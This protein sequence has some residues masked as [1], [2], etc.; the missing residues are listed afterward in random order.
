MKK[1][2]ML[3][4]VGL[5]CLSP[6][7]GQID[8]LNPICDLLEVYGVSNNTNR[9]LGDAYN[10][11]AAKAKYPAAIGFYEWLGYSQSEV[12]DMDE[13]STAAN[14]CWWATATVMSNMPWP[15]VL[16]GGSY[17]G[18][19]TGKGVVILPQGRFDT[20]MPLLIHNSG[21]ILCEGK[22]PFFER[23]D[24]YQTTATVLHP[25]QPNWV[26][27]PAAPSANFTAHFTN[28]I[29]NR[30][31]VV[32]SINFG[33]NFGGG[34][35][36]GLKIENL[37]IS[38]NRN[39]VG[40][41]NDP[42]WVGTGIAIYDMGETSEITNNYIEEMN[43]YG[44]ECVF[45][46][47]N[48]LYNNST[49]RCGL[50]GVMITG[51]GS[52]HSNSRIYGASGDDNGMALIGIQDG[53]GFTAGGTI[54]LY[55]IKH[56]ALG[57]TNY[58]NLTSQGIPGKGQLLF[59]S[60]SASHI[61]NLNI[62]GG[63]TKNLGCAIDALIRIQGAPSGIRNTVN[64]QGLYIYG[65]NAVANLLQVGG[66]RY[67]YP[68]SA[69]FMAH[70]FTFTSDPGA[71]TG[72]VVNQ[73]GFVMNASSSACTT[74]LAWLPWNGFTVNGSWNYT[75]C[76]PSWSPVTG[77]GGVVPPPP[78]PTPAVPTTVNITATPSAILVSGTSQASATILDQYNVPISGSITWSIV[79][80]PGTVNGS[81]FV[82][83]T[84]TAG[85]IIV[86]GT[87]VGYPLVTNTANIVVTAAPSS[88]LLYS[89]VFLGQN[90]LA[91]VPSGGSLAPTV[92]IQ[93]LNGTTG[94][95]TWRRGEI[96]GA[97]FSTTVSGV[98]PPNINC[99][100][101]LA[102]PITGV[103][104]IILKGA[105]I[106]D[107]VEYRHVNNKTRSRLNPGRF[108]EFGTNGSPTIGTY[109]LNAAASDLII[110]FTQ[111]M[112]ITHLL[113][114][115]NTIDNTIKMTMTAIELYSQP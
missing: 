103:R 58:T 99:R 91:L 61:L 7:A 29:F 69:N 45:G 35:C 66:N 68:P 97:T 21:Q 115:G 110:T 17:A 10:Y 22:R 87:V 39:P 51:G 6:A 94:R 44:I 76:Q 24:A 62:F 81:G 40:C 77:V 98:N 20:T 43:S 100:I 46:T 89:V 30:V 41:W 96:S 113:G 26:G 63:T 49:F 72:S 48:T 36:E 75:T 101:T 15:G 9:Q 80:G 90:P 33:G 52:G 27:P 32:R 83:N 23:T 13:L 3:V 42:T 107:P 71:T 64:V 37:F 19:G 56:E 85:T 12:L 74:R 8:P 25:D 82:T 65:S 92:S 67:P 84:G 55:G 18:G 2:L 109:T 60:E 104:K 28:A 4:L 111:P 93:S 73:N 57:S 70:S 108:F 38:G 11:A 86:R 88:N 105:R 16:P 112:T 34:Y 5:L 78:P 14:D 102:T 54:N 95:E 47:P 31:D 50:Y 53:Y 106:L 1:L 79:S 59:N 114:G